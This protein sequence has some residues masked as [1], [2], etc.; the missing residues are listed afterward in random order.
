VV[1]RNL[2]LAIAAFGVIWTYILAS[3]R[4]LY[5]FES[6]DKVAKT[7]HVTLCRE[8]SLYNVSG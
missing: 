1:T 2:I 4:S 5:P 3:S 8:G 7:S 6:P